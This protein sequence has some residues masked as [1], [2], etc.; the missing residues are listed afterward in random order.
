LTDDQEQVRRLGQVYADVEQLDLMICTL[1]EG[2]RPD[3][4]GFGETLFQI[5]ILNATRRPQ[6][7]RF[8]TDGYN[9]RT[10]TQEGLAWIDKTDL[11]TVILRH[12]PEL[13]ET[14]LAN[15]KNAREPWDTSER[16]APERHPL[17]AFDKALGPNPWRGDAS[18]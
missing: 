17:R 15:I 2:H 4:F 5:F 7:D 6:V 16:L 14:G 1:A 3:G 12:Y 9:E 11:K 10:Y 13:A 18:R 8:Y